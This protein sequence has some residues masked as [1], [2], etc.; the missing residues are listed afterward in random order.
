M[1]YSYLRVFTNDTARPTHH[2]SVLSSITI[3]CC[4][5]HT[6]HLIVIGKTT[7]HNTSK[8]ILFNHTPL[9]RSNGEK[10]ALIRSNIDFRKKENRLRQ[11]TSIPSPPRLSFIGE[12][13]KFFISTVILFSKVKYE[14]RGRMQRCRLL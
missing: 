6:G 11:N 8:T 2:F 3:E 10:I 5:H 14:Q 7:P 13:R 12:G 9:S 4:T 1:I